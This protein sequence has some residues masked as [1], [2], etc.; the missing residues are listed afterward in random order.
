M[1]L[2]ITA[3]L[4]EFNQEIF[5][6]LLCKRE[7]PQSCGLNLSPVQARA[8]HLHRVAPPETPLYCTHQHALPS[9]RSPWL[10]PERPISLQGNCFQNKNKTQI[11]KPGNK[12]LVFKD[13]TQF[14]GW[15]SGVHMTLKNVLVADIR[16]LKPLP[17]WLSKG[18]AKGIILSLVSIERVCLGN[19]ST[20]L[21]D[22]SSSMRERV[23]R[24][25][26]P[27]DIKYDS[28]VS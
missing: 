23:D 5:T 6:E 19:W 24:G 16:L 17:K 27:T 26:L 12:I 20:Q 9:S 22:I 3:G 2:V 21:G 4:Y 13:T 15:L 25:Q 7:V 11:H 28:K 1:H 18:T 8:L 10:L 14:F